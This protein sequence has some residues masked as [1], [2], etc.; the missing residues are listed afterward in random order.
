MMAKTSTGG[1]RMTVENRPLEYGRFVRANAVVLSFGESLRCGGIG[2]RTRRLRWT[3]LT[4]RCFGDLS[5]IATCA[6]CPL[7]DYPSSPC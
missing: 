1:S 5:A 2:R 4:E 3:Y 6:T 7:S